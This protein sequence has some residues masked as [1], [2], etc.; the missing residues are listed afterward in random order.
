M[1]IEM[2]VVHEKLDRYLKDQGMPAERRGAAL[3]AAGG[4]PGGPP[5]PG[6]PKDKP[7]GG[8]RV[9]SLNAT[10]NDCNL[11]DCWLCSSKLFPECKGKEMKHCIVFNIDI[12]VTK[13]PKLKLDGGAY[14]LLLAARKFVKLNPTTKTI[15]G[16]RFAELNPGGAI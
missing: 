6:P 15:K 11:C 5:K 13:Y 4:K 14:K 2:E 16:K 7:G 9:P 8:T 12:D 10:L 1:S 3:P